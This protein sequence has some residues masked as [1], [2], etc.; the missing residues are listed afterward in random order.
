MRRNR[1]RPA[2]PIT[3]NEGPGSLKFEQKKILRSTWIKVLT[4]GDA[5]AEMFYQRLFE[6]D[7]DLQPLFSAA[8]MVAQRKKLIQ[9]L[10]LV[11]NSLSDPEPL[12]AYLQALGRRHVEYGV[13]DRHYDTVEIAL[14]WTLEQVLGDA[15][16]DAVRDAWSDAYGIVA[17]EMK[18]NS[19]R[20]A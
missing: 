10:S 3:A 14:L 8:D 13:S 7:P 20:A 11:I 17:E 2:P 4:A 18:S 6:L 19:T 9:S 16:N 15:W 1:S 5:A 12:V